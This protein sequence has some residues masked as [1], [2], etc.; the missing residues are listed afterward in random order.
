DSFY[1]SFRARYLWQPT[2]NLTFNL[3]GEFN[4]YSETSG[5][6]WPVYQSTPS[7]RLSQLLGVCGIVPL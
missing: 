3:I 7:S 6:D 4:R 5:G 2:D 1:D